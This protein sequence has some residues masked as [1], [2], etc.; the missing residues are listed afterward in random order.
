MKDQ[1]QKLL[2]LADIKINGNRPWDIQVH[3]KDFYKR[4]LSGGSLALGES[5][6]DS[7]WDCEQLDEFFA[8]ILCADLD[9]K[10]ISKKFL[11]SLVKAKLF[12][13]QT[14]AKAKKSIKHHYDIGNDLYKLMLDKRMNYSCAYWNGAKTLDEAQ[15]QKL[16]MIC[17]KMKLKEGMKIVDI[18]SGWGAFCKYATEKYK[19]KSTGV[20]I[21]KEQA[22]L[23]KESCKGLS[24]EIKLIDYR[25]LGGEF[26]A[27]VS[28]GMVEHVG[29]KNHKEYFKKIY[30]LLP[31]G[32]IFLLHTIG[33][34]VSRI[35]EDPFIDKYIF[36]DSL[37]PSIK[38]LSEAT[39]GLFIIEDVHNFG[40][41]YDKTL[42]AWHENFN[43]NWDKI[44]D[45]Y[46]KRFFRMWNYYLLCCAG[47]FRA[48]N[49]Q[50]WQIVL[51]KG[52]LKEG[53]ERP[54][55]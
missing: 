18:G 44:K 30:D 46:D 54:Q 42:M 37:I 39:E 55:I 47:S 50:L 24:A 19:V 35:T 40:T 13:L 2:D 20:T 5:Y 52:R 9:K 17:K 53:Y 21:S 29:Q 3:H 12:N 15:E 32:G 8:K 4:V 31:E 45:K 28:I 14:K 26:D 51:T 43:R 48:R 33:S 34:P 16:D 22:N 38:Q 7:W 23:A 41:D 27:A 25:D 36:P 11:L 49:N 6:M 10:V 1:V